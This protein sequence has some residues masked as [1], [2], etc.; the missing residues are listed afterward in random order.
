MSSPKQDEPD[1]GQAIATVEASLSQLKQRYQQ[2]ERDQKRQQQLKELKQELKQQAK[3]NNTEGIIRAEL[4][5]IE[6]EIINLELNL[7]SRLWNWKELQEPFWQAVRY[8]GLGIIIGWILRL[9]SS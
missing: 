2:V 5:H 1:L 6:E 9:F 4:K 3:A 8:T 7:E